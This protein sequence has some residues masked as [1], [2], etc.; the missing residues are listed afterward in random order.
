MQTPI[1]YGW[2]LVTF[3]L[4]ALASAPAAELIPFRSGGWKYVLGTQEASNPTSAWRAPAFDDSAWLPG[5]TTASAPIG[6]PSAGATGVEGTIQTTLPTGTAGGYTCVFLRKTFVVTNAAAVVGLTLQVQHDDGFAAWINGTFA[7]NANVSEPY[8]IATVPTDHEVTVGE[9]LHTPSSSLLVEGTNVLAVQVF[10]TSAGSSDLF[11]DLTLT[12]SVDEAPTVVGTEPP[13]SAIVQSLTYVNVIFSE[14]VSGVDASDLLVESVAAT[15]VIQLTP[16]EYTFYFPAPANTGLVTVAWAPNPNI[17]DVDGLPNP[18]V[19]GPSWTYTIDPNIIPGAAVIS[20]FMADNEDAL[21]NGRP[22]EDED[23]SRSDWIEIYNPGLLEVGLNGWYLTDTTTNLIKWRIPAVVIAPN[24]YLLIWASEKNRANPAAPLHTNFRLSRN[25]GSYLALVDPSGVVVSSFGPNTV[26]GGGSSPYPGQLT[27]ISYG[28]DRVDPNLSGYFVTPTPGAQNDT[29]GTGFAA[30]PTASHD[31]GVYTNASL[32]FVITNPP[33]TTVRYTLNGTL[34]TNGSPAY[35]T[36]IS[37][38][39]NT[40]IKFRA[41]PTTAGVFPSEVQVR[42]FLFLDTTTRDFNSNLP[43]LILSSEGRSIPASVIPGGARAKGTFVVFDTFRGRSAFS[44]KPDFIGPADFEIFGQSSQG[45]AKQPFNIEIQ[46]ALGNDKAESILG[47]PE[48]ADWK[49]R[50]PFSDKCLMNDFLAYELFEQMGNYS[51]R[52][53]F[54]EV[55]VDSGGGRLVY[56]GDYIGVE[57]LFEKIERGDDRV[58]IAELTAAHTNEPAIT[59]GW[60]FRREPGKESDGDLNFSAGGNSL[61][62][63]EPKPQFMRTVPLRSGQSSWPGTNYTSSASNQLA[64]LV[65]FLNAMNGTM[66]SAGWT[67]TGTNHYSHYINVDKFVDEHWIVEFPKQIDGYR[68][69]AFFTKDRNGKLAPEPIWDW[70]LAF[71]N[72]DYLDGGNTNTWYYTLISAGDHTWLRQLLGAAA[73]PN[74]GGDPDFIQK[75][76]DR[77][78]VLRTNV[79]NGD[80][81]VSRI[82]ELATLLKDRGAASSPVTRNFAK[83]PNLNT[84]LW[85]NPQGPP[86]WHVDYTQPTYDLIISEMKKWTM[87]R[88]L[89][90]DNQFPKAPTLGVPEG[91]ITAGTPLVLAAASGTVYYTL[92]GADPRASQ[93]NGA[94][95]PGASTYSGSVILNDNARVFAR[96]RVGTTWSP[97]SIATYVVRRPRLV[98]TEI[99]Y[100]PLPPPLGS[101]NI[102]EDFEYIEVKNIESTPLNIGGYTIGGGISFTFPARTLAAGERVVVVNNQAAFLSRHPGLAGSIAGEFTGNLAN[103]GNRLI[104]RGRVREGLLDFEYDD[105]WY[106]I[107]D[108]FGFSLVIVDENAAASTWGLGSSWRPSGVLNGTPGQ[109]EGAPPSIPRVVINEALTHSD[110]APPTDTIELLNLSGAAA[111]VAGW[112]LTDDFRE[113]TKFRIPLNTPAI[114]A[115]GFLTFDE[116]A[117]NVG[118]NSFSLSSSGDEVYLFSADVEGDLTGYVHGFT[119]GPQLN[120]VTFVRHTVST[121]EE[122]FVAAS[123]STPGGVND[124]IRVGPIVI[125]EIMYRPPD[126]LANGAYWNNSE[127]EYIELKNVTGFPIS[128]YH[129]V[130]TSNTWKLDQ[131]VEFSFPPNTTIPA[132]GYAL[133]V[134]F[135]PATDLAQLAAFRAKYG[136]GAGVS[137][138]GP[139]RGDLS[140]GDETVA[141]YQ[142]DNP[143]TTGPD[144]GTVPYVVVDQVRYSDQMPWPVTADGYGQTLHR[145]NLTAYGDDPSNWTA[146]G[147]TAS[148]PYV[149]GP[150]PVITAHPGNQTVSDSGTATATFTAGAIGQGPLRYQWLFNGSI[151]NGATSS[152]LVIQNVKPSD[153]GQY[154]VSVLNPFGS[155]VSTAGTL[156]VLIAPK[157]TQHPVDQRINEGANA[158]FAVIGVSVVPPLRYQWYRDGQSIPNGT[159]FFLTLNNVVSDVDDGDYSV[160]ISDNNGTVASS[161]GRLTVMLAPL[162]L[163][164][165]PRLGLTAVPGQTLTL[166]TQVRGTKPIWLQWRKFAATG[167]NQG[168]LKAGFINSNQDFLVVTNISTNNALPNSA[169][170]YTLQF[171]NIAGGNLSTVN[172]R[173]NA[174]LTVLLDS[175]ANGIDDNWESTYF[176]SPTG[177]DRE[178]DTD[179]DTMSNWAEYTAGTDPTN[180]ASYLKVEG[181][182]ATG[183]ATITFQAVAGRTY[184]VEYADDL[185]SA[186]WSKLADV[187]PQSANGVATVTD[188]ASQPD[189]YYRLV[190]PRRP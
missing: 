130:H 30:S 64:Y 28:R 125:S 139:Y 55:F 187:T 135:N 41:F 1:K 108:G 40:T 100:H 6:Y 128:L 131:A 152:T 184:T 42:N 85:P 61:K 59:G 75:V 91:D 140:N 82:D 23:G 180:A 58:D 3:L 88:Y 11:L 115:G 153:A 137:I 121:G 156:T 126:V 45:F 83:H 2:R 48:E 70:N 102:D 189:R 18:F 112:Y 158:T 145:V 69:S 142:P 34:P 162:L 105:Q 47:L 93:S 166:G 124:S 96:A 79:M 76:I 38:A 29:S 149:S 16:R 72:A 154:Q 178:A 95:A 148:T 52:R 9:A 14:N 122:H 21:Y 97:P 57:V 157:I 44:R 138:F 94:V 134:N 107:T 49:L 66:N 73:L 22:I 10:N 90:I 146:G 12:S 132:N 173:T 106:P 168:L 133:V 123:S 103:D 25:A 161:S 5:G 159:N 151:L 186:V 99:M 182:S 174:I 51:C 144:A 143:E 155:A 188:P 167:G 185:T 179:G 31:S 114:P 20:E 43:I 84:Y 87:G 77:W 27:D 4:A 177:A 176:G 36:P 172:I 46:D 136:V 65:R 98:I 62:L 170:F 129:S 33:G 24:K 50:N 109:G 13:P 190:T 15:N 127:D 111:S 74:S 71:G 175:N 53:R 147:P 163:N 68:L 86:T 92:D 160:V 113:P 141:L 26:Q 104:L 117:F 89:W 63:T 183:G 35:S 67:A 78:G 171:T 110:P 119:F 80:R 81:V 169:G 39:N 17:N 8:T 164:P 101:T 19:P 56:P 118:P 7:G 181:I 165:V 32:T 60:I 37:V 116:S 120:G 54:V 150:S